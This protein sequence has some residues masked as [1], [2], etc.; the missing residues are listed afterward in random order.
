MKQI[1]ICTTWE[2]YSQYASH[3]GACRTDIPTSLQNEPLEQP[4][5]IWQ[6]GGADASPAIV[7]LLTRLTETSHVWPWVSSSGDWLSAPMRLLSVFMLSWNKSCSLHLHPSV[8][9]WRFSSFHTWPH[10]FGRVNEGIVSRITFGVN[11]WPA[12]KLNCF[13]FSWRQFRLIHFGSFQKSISNWLK[14]KNVHDPFVL[15]C[16]STSRLQQK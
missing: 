1:I 9:Y 3:H 11:S 5:S 4:D 16:N 8:F 10:F 6:P 7:H 2:D 12:P 14:W 15:S 13:V